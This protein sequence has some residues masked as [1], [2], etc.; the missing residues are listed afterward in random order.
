M[1]DRIFQIYVAIGSNGKKYVGQTI[2]GI[3]H[4]KYMHEWNSYGLCASDLSINQS[5]TRE[6][7]L[8][9]KGFNSCGGYTFKLIT[10][11]TLSQIESSH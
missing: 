7:V 3:K 11:G 4:R 10:G 8:G 1:A 5:H 6:C 9:H 2:R